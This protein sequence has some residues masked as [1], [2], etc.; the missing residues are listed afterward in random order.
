[1]WQ[2]AHRKI[3][4]ELKYAFYQTV[5]VMVGY[6]FLGM[7]FG[8]M[9]QNAGYSAFWAFLASLTIYAG[10]MQFVLVSILSTGLGLPTVALMTL[11]INSRHFF[12]G[13]PFLEKFRQTGRRFIYMVFSLTDETYAL[14]Y[15]L[16]VPDGLDK[17]RTMFLI[18]LLNQLYWVLGSVLGA[19]LGGLARFNLKGIDFSMTALFAVILVE[20]W[21]SSG[22]SGHWSI[23]TGL[24]SGVLALLIFGPGRFVLP[25]L[26]LAA[27]LLVVLRP[28]L[29]GREEDA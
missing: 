19:A 17:S 24:S 7:A 4:P 21:R 13:L 25:A 22:K 28:K 2:K 3:G 12:Y 29:K 9:L 11:S 18:A 27:G 14:L 1:M 26:L 23:L 20:Q 10:S 15:S 8:L 16:N 6:A 5:P